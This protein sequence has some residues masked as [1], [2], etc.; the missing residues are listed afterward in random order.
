MK[1]HAL[2]NITKQQSQDTGMAM[3]L[4]LLLASLPAKRREF[5]LAAI[6]L[7]VFNMTLPQ[8]YRPL[9]V[10]WLG[11][12]HLLG[13]VMSKILLTLV[14]FAVV[15]PMAILRRLRGKDSLQLRVFKQGDTSVMVERKHTFTAA[16]LERLY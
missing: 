4:L 8:I 10:V 7:Q 14:F 6:V 2:K 9:A 5:I 16:D 1:D 13:T 15:T 3:V 12:S 11:F